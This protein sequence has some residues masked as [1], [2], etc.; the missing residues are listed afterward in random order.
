MPMLIVKV[1]SEPET[2][3]EMC[4]RQGHTAWGERG[5]CPFPVI[6]CPLGRIGCLTVTPEHWRK[7]FEG[8]DKQEPEPEPEMP[9]QFGDKVTL[10][11]S[12]GVFN[13]I[14]NAYTEYERAYVLLE[15]R[16]RCSTELVRNLKAGWDD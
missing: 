16:D 1:L 4:V 10:V 3:A 2:L 14:F 7:V 8:K 6:E 5:C 12:A 11:S 13:G 15:G 9:F